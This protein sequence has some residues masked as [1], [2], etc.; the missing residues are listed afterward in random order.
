MICAFV[1]LFFKKLYASCYTEFNIYFWI[2]PVFVFGGTP[3]R[4]CL[5]AGGHVFFR[6]GQRDLFFLHVTPY[7]RAPRDESILYDLEMNSLAGEQGGLSPCS[8][9]VTC[10]YARRTKIGGLPDYLIITSIILHGDIASSACGLFAGM[11]IISPA[12]RL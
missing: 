3:S 5:A 7:H 4:A 9:C 8:V 10:V 11:M 6:T 1:Q 12:D 2:I